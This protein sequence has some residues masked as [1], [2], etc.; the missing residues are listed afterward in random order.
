M[1]MEAYSP[2]GTGKLLKDPGLIA[3]AEKYG[4]SVAQ[5]CIRW[6]LQKGVVPLPK[7]INPERIAENT[8]VFDFEISDEDM[9]ILDHIPNVGWSGTV[10]DTVKWNYYI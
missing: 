5:L 10:V 2:I 3:M 6:C 1:I 8:K 9:N 4:K 7:S